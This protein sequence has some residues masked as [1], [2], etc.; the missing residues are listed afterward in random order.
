MFIL[1]LSHSTTKPKNGLCTQ[2]R[3]WSA[4]TSAQSDQSLCCWHEE[5]LVLQPCTECTA[6]TLIR[7]SGCPGW[8]VFAGRKGHFVGFVMRQLNFVITSSYSWKLKLRSQDAQSFLYIYY[9]SQSMTKPTKWPV[10]PVKTRISLHIHT[11]WSVFTVHS[12]EANDHTCDIFLDSNRE[13]WV[14]R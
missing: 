14:Y 2:R 13:I 8:S 1:Q 4:W 9:V 12:K 5:S 3:L 6:K 10:H 7:L 11:I